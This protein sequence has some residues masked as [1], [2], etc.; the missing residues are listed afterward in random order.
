VRTRL[1]CVE[2]PEVLLAL[3]TESTMAAR[4]LGVL[5]SHV[6]ATR[7]RRAASSGGGGGAVQRP[8]LVQVL[9]TGERGVV[10]G[11]KEADPV[12]GTSGAKVRVR[13]FTGTEETV[14]KDD[15]RVRVTVIFA[16]RSNASVW[17]AMQCQAPLSSAMCQSCTT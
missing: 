8:T 2:S 6:R 13:L 17:Y 7:S 15:V 12:H 4:R 3:I 14:D 5:A 1:N 16:L 10:V 11:A 9:H